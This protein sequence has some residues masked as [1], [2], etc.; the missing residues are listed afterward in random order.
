MVTRSTSWDDYETNFLDVIRG[1][2]DEK[3]SVGV[4]GDI[5]IE[6]HRDWVERVCSSIG[7]RAVLPLWKSGR[8]DLLQEFFSLGFSAIIVSV[9]DGALDPEFLGKVLDRSI[10]DEMT[11]IGV[12]VSGEE[13]EYHTLVTNGPTFSRPIETT[14]RD[15]HL[16]DG[17]WFLDLE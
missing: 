14:P 9:K 8:V 12:D 1:L 10:I 15:I 7:V 5:D 17:Y 11:R 4:F 16:K 2:R 6:Q 3:V 13:G